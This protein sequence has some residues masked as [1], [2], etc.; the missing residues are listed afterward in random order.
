MGD[1]WYRAEI[2]SY[3]VAD[4]WG[5]HSHSYQELSW[6]EYQVE[7]YTPR[8]VWVR[9]YHLYGERAFI[10]GVGKKQLALPTKEL[11]LRDLRVRCK[12]HVAGCE[13]RL[14]KA[15]EGLNIVER[16]LKNDPRYAGRDQ[17][18]KTADRSGRMEF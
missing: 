13:A 9:S 16:I 8:G 3:S 6:R 18:T 15:Q 12:R 17:G 7:K 4:E 10:R 1:M 11:A 14:G 5:D 2:R